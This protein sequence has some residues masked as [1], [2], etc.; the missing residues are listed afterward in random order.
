MPW[1]IAAA[2]VIVVLVILVVVGG[3]TT[4]VTPSG[5]G[6]AEPDSYA[7]KLPISG[8]QMSEATSFSGAKVTYIDGQIANTGD[9]TLT[10]VTVQVGFHD[11]AGQYAQRLAVPLNLIRTREPYVDTQPVSAAPI[12]P[13]QT[14]DFR[15]IFDS[16]PPDWNLQIPEI[17]V[18]NVRGK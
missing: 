18:I 5:T 10:A 3:R 15:L 12:E 13:G 16:V 11:D 1:I 9:R 7:P 4:P 17:R 8:L 14:R 6:M 2:V